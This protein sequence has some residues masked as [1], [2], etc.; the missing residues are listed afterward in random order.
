MTAPFTF[1]GLFVVLIA[2]VVGYVLWMWWY[3]RGREGEDAGDP[4]GPGGGSRG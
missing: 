4:P 3:E 1:W 2:I